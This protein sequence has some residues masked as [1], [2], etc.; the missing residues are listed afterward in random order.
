MKTVAVQ[1]QQCSY[2][3][4]SGPIV[5]LRPEILNSEHLGYISRGGLSCVQTNTS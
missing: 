1:M 4:L 5:E 2:L 3:S